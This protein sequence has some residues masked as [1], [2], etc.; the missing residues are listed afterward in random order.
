MWCR[1][2][3]GSLVANA[4]LREV[5]GRG[6]VH[7]SRACRTRQASRESRLFCAYASMDHAV[8][9]RYENLARARVSMG[10]RAVDVL[11]FPPGLGKTPPP[12]FV[13]KRCFFCPVVSCFK[14]G[15]ASVR[16]K[17]AGPAVSVLKRRFL[18]LAV[19]FVLKPKPFFQAQ[20]PPEKTN[21]LRP[22]LSHGIPLAARP[23][24]GGGGTHGCAGTSSRLSW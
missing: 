22:P 23:P 19:F 3:V 21:F 20:V 6:A 11:T 15:T 17:T 16:E 9:R 10:R 13:L 14:T 24:D 12:P 18:T 2:N 8:A 4:R 1:S 7:P 5:Q